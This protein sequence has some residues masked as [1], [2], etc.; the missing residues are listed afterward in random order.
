VNQ[1]TY[2]DVYPW[3]FG[4]TTFAGN[5]YDIEITTDNPGGGQTFETV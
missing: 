2:L 4:T 1:T 5:T 3:T